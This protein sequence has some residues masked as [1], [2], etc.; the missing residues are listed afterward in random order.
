MALF[1]FNALP[2]LGNAVENAE[3]MFLWGKHEQVLFRTA[4]ILSTST[5][6]GNT[7]TTTLRA[8]LVL[9]QLSSNK[10]SPYDANATD[11]SQV[12][13]GILCSDVKMLGIEGSVGDRLAVVVVGGPVKGGQLLYN[14][15]VAS[16]STLTGLD[17][18]A[19]SHF[20]GRVTFDDDLV[21]NQ[22]PWK[23]G[24]AKTADYT[25]VASDNGTVFETTG[26]AGAVTF[27]LPALL[28]ANSNPVCKGVRF[29][30]VNTVDQNMVISIAGSDT[31]ICKNN[32][33]GATATFSTTN[34]KI[35]S[36]AVVYTN[37]AGTK[38]IV[39]VLSDTTVTVA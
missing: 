27:T 21:G 32:A 14:A 33:A 30:F 20:R 9:S 31:L 7:P 10:W 6:N 16:S 38:W 39:E 26:A 22:Y 17:Y 19:R 37:A 15:P 29:K 18:Q 3:R 5:D 24:L 34:Q 13:Q 25:V 35:G 11:G 28:D 2:G 36:I 12:A 1:D 23:Q 8:G 4:V